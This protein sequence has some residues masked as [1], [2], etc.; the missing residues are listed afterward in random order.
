[1]SEVKLFR[2]HKRQG[3][4]FIYSSCFSFFFSMMPKW[5]S[6]YWYIFLLLTF[7]TER[8]D[9]IQQSQYVSWWHSALLIGQWNNVLLKSV[10]YVS[11]CVLSLLPTNATKPLIATASGKHEIHLSSQTFSHILQVAFR[12]VMFLFVLQISLADFSATMTTQLKWMNLVCNKRVSSN[13]S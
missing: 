4:K 11:M 5:M 8:D 7:R 1:M 6:T 9:F 13:I 10:M 2:G 3:R 12:I